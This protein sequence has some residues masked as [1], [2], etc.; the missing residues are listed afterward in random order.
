MLFRPLV[1]NEHTGSYGLTIAA[2]ALAFLVSSGPELRA[3]EAA[4]EGAD[5]KIEVLDVTTASGS[6]IPGQEDKPPLKIEIM[7]VG[8]NMGGRPAVDTAK[9]V[10]GVEY[11]APTKSKRE[12]LLTSMQRWHYN[13]LNSYR[14]DI[15][16]LADPFM[17][18]KEVRGAHVPNRPVDNDPS[19]LPPLLR[20]E[21]NQLKLVA[22]TTQQ[23]LGLAS[24]EDGAG[25]GY[26]LR[27]GDRIGRNHGKI[28]RIVTNEVWVE[29]RGRLGTD[30][31]RTTVIKLNVLD[32]K[33]LTRASS[34][35]PSGAT[36]TLQTISV[37]GE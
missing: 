29:E 19:S 13:T 5:I 20:L 28:T 32:T 22:I 7:D 3:Q 11:D 30:P 31:P 23:S 36:G 14:Y 26:I 18:I 17:P 8:S 35:A 37:P 15:A 21:L 16:G 33:G 6:K 10:A 4:A 1:T 12:A 25:N 24:F 27:T 2:L 34:D 9:S